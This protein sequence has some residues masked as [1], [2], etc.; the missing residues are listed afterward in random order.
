MDEYLQMTKIRFPPNDITYGMDFRYYGGVP[1]NIVWGVQVQ[2]PD[3]LVLVAPGYGIAGAYGSGS[4]YVYP[5][6][7]DLDL[8]NNLIETS[9]KRAKE[10]HHDELTPRFLCSVIGVCEA[11][12][13]HE[14]SRSCAECPAG[15][16]REKEG[17][18]CFFNQLT[19]LLVQT[20]YGRKVMAGPR[21]C[22]TT[23]SRA[24]DGGSRFS[25][26]ANHGS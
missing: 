2:K 15:I 8:V 6:G 1:T 13:L 4:I 11:G 10:R 7:E 9:E 22:V 24:L 12:M 14:C 26:E 20:N 16:H 25:G 23:K 18:E 21:P 3:H 5:K 19:D 17:P